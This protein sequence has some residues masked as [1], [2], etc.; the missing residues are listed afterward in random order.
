MYLCCLRNTATL[1]SSP[2]SSVP[3]KCCEG[4]CFL[5]L[6]CWDNLLTRCSLF[7]ISHWLPHSNNSALHSSHSKTEGGN[8]LPGSWGALSYSKRQMLTSIVWDRGGNSQFTSPSVFQRS[9][10]LMSFV[11][12][13]KDWD[14]TYTVVK[15]SF[16]QRA[17]VHH[18]GV[19]QLPLWTA[20]RSWARQK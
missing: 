7:D 8:I 14:H 18:Q 12:W 17:I 5:W 11:Y 6:L 15:T 2:A 10:V 16:F 3:V 4:G 1:Q 9:P 19:A 13:L 20:F